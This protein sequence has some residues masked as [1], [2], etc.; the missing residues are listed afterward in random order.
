M[1]KIALDKDLEIIILSALRYAIPR[2]SYCPDIVSEFIQKNWR[3]F[4]AEFQQQIHDELIKYI[5]HHPI[6]IWEP[7]RLLKIDDKKS[8]SL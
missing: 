4:S 1:H 7:V 5:G 2:T 6:A 8:D 3:C